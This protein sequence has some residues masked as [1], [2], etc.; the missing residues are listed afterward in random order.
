MLN[1][2]FPSKCP[3]C[4][5]TSDNHLHN[6][7]CSK[8]WSSIERYSG[9]SCEVCGIPTASPHTTI[10]E[11]CL[12]KKPPFSKVLYYGIYTGALKKTIHLLKFNKLKRLSSPLCLLLNSLP[13]PEVDGIV[14]V[15]LH[16]KRLRQREFNQTANISRYL[17]KELKVPLMLNVL[18]K[19]RKT[20]PQTDIPGKERLKNVKNSFRSSENITGLRLLLVDDVITT[21]ATVKES[22]KALIDSGAKEVV[23]VALARSMPK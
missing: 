23:V 13:I 5:S 11:S 19:V 3:L 4:E 2:L 17:S 7:V 18:E 10:C 9:P 16:L 22:A 15:P 6:P 20:P 8:C 14:P 12:S 21:G 1:L